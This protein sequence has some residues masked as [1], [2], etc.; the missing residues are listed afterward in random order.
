MVLVS[1]NSHTPLSQEQEMILREMVWLNHGCSSG[2]LYGDDGEMQCNK[3]MID[4]KRMAPSQ[5]M[6]IRTQINIKKLKSASID[7]SLLT[8]K[9]L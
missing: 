7:F 4:F 3:C 2:A 1:E 5:I 6:E 9:S 8:T